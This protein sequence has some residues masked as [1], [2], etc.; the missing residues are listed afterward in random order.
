MMI[1]KNK[2]QVILSGL[3]ERSIST[4]IHALQSLKDSYIETVANTWDVVWAQD[5]K[6]KLTTGNVRYIV[7]SNTRPMRIA[8]PFIDVKQSETNNISKLATFHNKFVIFER[9]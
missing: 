6:I 7:F 2:K 9:K 1:D 3:T 4:M 8:I 5:A